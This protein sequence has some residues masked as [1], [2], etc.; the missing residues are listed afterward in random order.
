ML[1]GLG[2]AVHPVLKRVPQKVPM[3]TKRIEMINTIYICIRNL[4]VCYAIR[5]NEQAEAEQYYWNCI[6]KLETL[7]KNQGFFLQESIPEGYVLIMEIIPRRNR[8]SRELP[9]DDT[10]QAV[11]TD[12]LAALEK[13]AK[14][15]KSLPFGECAA[16][17][18][19]IESFPILK[20]AL[21]ELEVIEK[22]TP[23]EIIEYEL[24]GEQS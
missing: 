13:V 2:G 24:E 15:V 20:A 9:K 17:P 16:L 11:K 23:K 12:K 19:C 10:W 18:Y 7:E 3:D 4:K 22:E 6:D 5:T 21:D 14:A 1:E 8:F